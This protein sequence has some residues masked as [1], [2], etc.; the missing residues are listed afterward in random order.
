MAGIWSG[1]GSVIRPSWSRVVV[2]HILRRHGFKPFA[3]SLAR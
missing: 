2:P 3:V 1:R